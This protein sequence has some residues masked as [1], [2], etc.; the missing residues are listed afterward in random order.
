VNDGGGDLRTNATDDEIG[1]HEPAGSDGLEQ[2]VRQESVDGGDAGD[3]DDRNGGSG[4]DD[5]LGRLSMTIWVRSLSRVP[6]SGRATPEFDDRRRELKHLV[7]LAG[8]DFLAAFL[9]GPDRKQGQL[10][11]QNGDLPEACCHF[12]GS[13]FGEVHL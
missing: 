9:I 7:L 4:F 13:A 3:I 8:D 5:L 11:E 10:V 1:A 2:L 12:F 6:M